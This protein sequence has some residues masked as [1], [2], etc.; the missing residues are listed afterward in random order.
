MVKKLLANHLGDG[1]FIAKSFLQPSSA[2][3]HIPAPAGPQISS[4]RFNMK[5][6][7][8]NVIIGGNSN[9]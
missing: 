4:K 8:V 6:R 5:L 9:L 3:T 1:D 2:V 7:H